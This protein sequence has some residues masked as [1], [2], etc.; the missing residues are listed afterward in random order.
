VGADDDDDMKTFAAF[1]ASYLAVLLFSFGFLKFGRLGRLIAL[2]LWCYIPCGVLISV[3]P[4]E[5]AKALVLGRTIFF[6]FAFILSAIL[7]FSQT[8]NAGQR[9]RS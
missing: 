2:V 5:Q 7:F 8:A 9:I 6:V 1:H 3:L 4:V